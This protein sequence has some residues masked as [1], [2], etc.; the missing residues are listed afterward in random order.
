MALLNEVYN[1]RYDEHLRRRC[2]SACT[3]KAQEILAEPPSTP[4][5]TSRL[6]WAE[7]TF[8]DP[9]AE[10][11]KLMWKIVQNPT[12]QAK[13]SPDSIASGVIAPDTDIQFTINTV[14]DAAIVD[15]VAMAA[16]GAR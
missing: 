14:V 13:Q 16:G 11:E 12:L 4:N 2:T 6:A 10:T 7:A 15:P 9:V 8:R 5:H 1:M 3:I